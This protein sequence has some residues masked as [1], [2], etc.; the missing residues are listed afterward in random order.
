MWQTKLREY[1]VQWLDVQHREAN[2][3]YGRA[4]KAEGVQL[5]EELSPL[6]TLGLPGDARNAGS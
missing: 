5:F 2:L 6:P 3:D 4:N 1:S